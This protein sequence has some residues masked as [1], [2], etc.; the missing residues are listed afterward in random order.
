MGLAACGASA[1]RDTFGGRRKAA[2]VVVGRAIV[3]RESLDPNR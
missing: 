1:D 2:M 3:A